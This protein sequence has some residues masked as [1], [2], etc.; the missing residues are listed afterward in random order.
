MM[1]KKTKKQVTASQSCLHHR[2]LRRLLPGD[3]AVAHTVVPQ[4]GRRGPAPR[5]LAPPQGRGPAAVVTARVSILDLTCPTLLSSR[6]LGIA[7]NR[8]P[9]HGIGASG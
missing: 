7:W 3:A 4:A 2:Q 1:R 9:H 6:C 8:Q 5:L